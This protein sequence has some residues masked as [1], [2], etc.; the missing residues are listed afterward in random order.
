LIYLNPKHKNKQGEVFHG[1]VVVGYQHTLGSQLSDSMKAHL[2]GL[3]QQRLS[4]A[5]VMDH[6]K[7]YV[8]EKALKNEPITRDIFVLPFDVK[9][10]SRKRVD[11]LWQKH[12]KDPM[13]VKIWDM[14]NPNS[15][16]YYVEHAPMYLNLPSQDDTPF[17]FGIQTPWQAKNDDKVWTQEFDLF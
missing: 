14:E 11:G 15:I 12:P 5:Q 9:I 10:L 3:L 16:F 13:N 4:P 6:H 17:T 2:M 8:R 7:V 1:K